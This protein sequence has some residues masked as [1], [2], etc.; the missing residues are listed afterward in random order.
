MEYALDRR[1]VEIH[2]ADATAWG[3]YTCPVCHA[4]A[5]LRRGTKRAPHFAH[6][7]GEGSLD[8]ELYFPSTYEG[9]SERASAQSV[10]PSI[11]VGINLYRRSWTTYFRLPRTEQKDGM[12]E[13][14]GH[15]GH[16]AIPFG[17]LRSGSIVPVR[18][19]AYYSFAVRIPQT[20]DATTKDVEGLSLN[21]FSIFR[22]SAIGGGRLPTNPVLHWGMP[23]SLV[24]RQ[25]SQPND[26]PPQDLWI[27]LDQQGNWHCGV[28]ELPS[29]PRAD[30]SAWAFRNLGGTIV[31]GDL[32]LSLIWPTPVRWSDEHT[33]VISTTEAVVALHVPSGSEGPEVLRVLKDDGPG[34]SVKV[35]SG[36]TDLLLLLKEIGP[37]FTDILAGDDQQ[38][39]TLIRGDEALPSL[40]RV[41]VVTGTTAV[42]LFSRAAAEV[43]RSSARIALG[44]PHGISGSV[45]TWNSTHLQWE[46]SLVRESEFGNL[47]EPSPILVWDRRT[48]MVVDFGNFGRMRLTPR[49]TGHITSAR[50]LS[51]SQRSML[52]WLSQQPLSGTGR[53][54]IGDRDALLT[55]ASSL[56]AV[57]RMLVE[58]LA[59]RH[60][61]PP[62]AQVLLRQLLR[63]LGV[64]E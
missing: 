2:A 52:W 30:V 32:A 49:P 5:H 25:L 13:F 58:R 64:E 39:L 34:F 16:H 43:A 57:D 33:A 3:P 63:E 62:F 41:D 31:A 37:G 35:G 28:L 15:N 24:W 29:V 60:A 54:V 22:Y 47:P 55:W 59:F 21:G 38:P 6:N 7:S 19:Q 10:T 42:P 14:Q 4:R 12:I 1:G 40:A 20:T 9:S 44:I 11:V 8:C 56:S 45:L 26:W 27:E 17:A 18:P 61:W 36:E 48:E 50:P 46:T 53:A 51:P 23:Y